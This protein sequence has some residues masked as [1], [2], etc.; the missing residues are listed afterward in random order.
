VEAILSSSTQVIIAS[1]RDSLLKSS[2]LGL[3]VMSTLIY[4]PKKWRVHKSRTS[5]WCRMRQNWVLQVVK[6]ALQVAM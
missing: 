2:E 1:M 4:K 3:M 5:H 6:S